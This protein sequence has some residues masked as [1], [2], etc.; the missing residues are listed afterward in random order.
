MPITVKKIWNSIS[1]LDSNLFLPVI[2]NPLLVMIP[3]CYDV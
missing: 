2:P 3:V 1:E